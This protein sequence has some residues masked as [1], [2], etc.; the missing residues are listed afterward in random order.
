MFKRPQ[1]STWRMRSLY[2]GVILQNNSLKMFLHLTLNLSDFIAWRNF[3]Q[4]TSSNTSYTKNFI[5][6]AQL[7][8]E[9]NLLKILL[10]M[11]ERKFSTHSNLTC[12]RQWIQ[13][14]QLIGTYEASG[15]IWMQGKSFNDIKTI[16]LLLK[17]YV[18]AVSYT[19]WI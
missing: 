10:N 3:T 11:P 16:F 9:G 18:H 13:L 14:M 7:R 2:N 4:K 17:C 5:S 8:K 15:R 1:H 12:M 6:T 19:L